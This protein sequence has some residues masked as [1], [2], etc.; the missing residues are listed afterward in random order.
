LFH[1]QSEEFVFEIAI[2]YFEIEKTQKREENFFNL[3][4]LIT[5]ESK[6]TLKKEDK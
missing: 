3:V 4:L 2:F 5:P 6:I 1:Q